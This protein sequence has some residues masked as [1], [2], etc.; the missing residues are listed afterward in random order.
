MNTEIFAP[1]KKY[2]WLGV[3]GPADTLAIPNDEKELIQILKQTSHDTPIH[4]IGA[5]SNILVRDKGIRGLVIKLGQRW[6]YAHALESAPNVLEVGAAT[7]DIKTAN[8]ALRAGLSG[9]EF[10]VGIPGSLGGAIRMNAGCFGASTSEHLIS[11]TCVSREGKIINIPKEKIDF[12]YRK[13]SIPLD[14][15]VLSAKFRLS[16]EKQNIIK[17]RMEHISKQRKSRQP[18]NVK[19]GGSTFKNPPN[20]SAWELID[21]V[22]G[23]NM[24]VGDASFSNIHCNFLINNDNASAKDLETLAENVR[25]KVLENTNVNLEWEII[26]WGEK[27]D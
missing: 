22:G 8:S 20:Q 2:T 26:R 11:V 1:M 3:G 15:I 21:R 16:L 13:S 14:H 19:T 23:R 10:M 27:D 5:G 25:K 17:E 4:I 24:S 6:N 9:L 18:T 12:Q 7:P